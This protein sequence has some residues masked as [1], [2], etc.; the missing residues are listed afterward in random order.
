M[1]SPRCATSS[2]PR[3]WPEGNCA[4]QSFLAEK[5]CMDCFH[6][7]KATNVF[8]FLEATREQLDTHCT[9]A[10]PKEF[11]NPSQHVMLTLLLPA[12]S[13]QP[14]LLM[15]LCCRFIKNAFVDHLQTRSRPTMLHNKSCVH[16]SG[17][18]SRCTAA[19]VL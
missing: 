7:W 2:L 4:M 16:D 19:Y 17:R 9:I 13:S 10:K 5:A 11:E 3:S 18:D 12:M 14:H 8:Y 1:G 15:S 6:H